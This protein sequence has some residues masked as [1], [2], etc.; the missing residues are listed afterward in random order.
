MSLESSYFERMYAE[1]P[2]PWSLASRWYEERKYAVTMAS[3]TRGTYQRGFEP[4][5]SVGVLTQLLAERCDEL[6]ATDVVP[7]AVEATQ[8]RV[9]AHRSVEVRQLSVPHEWPDGAFDLIVISELGYY[10][11]VSD[12]A[13]LVDQAAGALQPDGEL[14]AVHWRH[15][16]PD[17]PLTGDQV[18]A[19]FRADPRLQSVASHQEDDFRL[20]LLAPVGARSVAD[21]E[22]LV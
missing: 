15:S 14:L 16:V 3:L 4:G 22:G 19:L 13:A 6:L 5:C 2:D 20:D 9:R 11:S 12:L 8:H 1:N 18:Q 17:Y 7:E 21:R 10:L